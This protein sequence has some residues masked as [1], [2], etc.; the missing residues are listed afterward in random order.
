MFP[1]GGP[2]LDQFKESSFTRLWVKWAFGGATKVLCQ[3]PAWRTF[4]LEK[5]NFLNH[6]CPIIFNW[7]AT[8]RLL[9]LGEKKL[10]IKSKHPLNILYLGWLEEEKGIFDFLD[11]CS[12]IKKEKE[13]KILIAGGGSREND[14]KEF[15]RK[16]GTH[17][18]ATF[19][20]WVEG[21]QL[22]EILHNSD[23]LV[24]PSWAEGF[25]NA[26]IEAMASGLAVVV[27]SV[28]NVTDILTH[29]SEALLVIPRHKASLINAISSLIDDDEL[30]HC[31]A[32]Q[33][34]KFSKENF[35][36]EKSVSKLEELIYSVIDQP[37]SGK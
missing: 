16:N 1:R 15:C 24:L 27:T 33:G 37:K 26:V 22:E 5:L 7:T 20:G 36:V 3:G 25:P 35:S 11:A 14:V 13:F 8:D 34:H 17:D 28:G 29:K 30:R 10:K 2:L 18:I 12:E 23:I 6:N 19:F 31:I 9:R 4:A 21:A 32:L